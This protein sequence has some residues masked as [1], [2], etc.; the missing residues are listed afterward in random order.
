[1]NIDIKLSMAKNKIRAHQE[2][3]K[4]SAAVKQ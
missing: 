2:K 3:H 1:M 4:I